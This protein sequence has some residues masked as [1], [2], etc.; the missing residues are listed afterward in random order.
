MIGDIEEE[1][2]NY[3]RNFAPVPSGYLNHSNEVAFSF[4]FTL[5]DKARASYAAESAASRD[6]DLAEF[7]PMESL[8]GGDS[9]LEFYR[10]HAELM[11]QTARVKRI[12]KFYDAAVW[13]RFFRRLDAA[14]QDDLG[15]SGSSGKTPGRRLVE[16]LFAQLVDREARKEAMSLTRDRFIGRVLEK[17][18]VLDLAESHAY[19]VNRGT[20]PQNI[21][22][23][24]R[25]IRLYEPMVRK[26]QSMT[27]PERE[28]G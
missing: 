2:P 7:F 17:K 20:K 5:Y 27:D 22:S 24:A 16:K 21:S 10:L 12:A 8:L 25:F 9:P 13:F 4:L 6:Q 15:A 1:D 23:I 18:S 14:G 11:G 19:H 28:A 3:F 26:E